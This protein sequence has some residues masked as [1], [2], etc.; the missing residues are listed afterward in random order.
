MRSKGEAMKKSSFKIFLL[1]FL[2]A[3]VFGFTIQANA[4]E[5]ADLKNAEI[6]L[7]SPQTVYT[8][9][10][11]EI[12]PSVAYV[13]CNGVTLSKSEYVISYQSN[14]NVGEAKVVVNASDSSANYYGSASKSFTITPK[15][16]E[17]ANVY[18]TYTKMTYWGTTC[19]P[20]VAGASVDGIS[21]IYGKD[22]LVEY[23]NN[24]NPGK[25]YV[26]LNGYG[27]FTGSVKK[28]F[29]INPATVS[30]VVQSESKT[31]SVT[32]NWY[33]Q[34]GISEYRIYEKTD[35]G[36]EYLTKSK[37][38]C[39]TIKKLNPSS[40][41]TYRIRA[42]KEIDSKN[43]AGDYSAEICAVTVPSRVNLI[44]V[45]K[46]KKDSKVNWK[47]VTCSKY[48]ILYCKNKNFSGDVKVKIVSSKDSSA[49]IKGIA[50]TK[51]Y[52]KI[53][54]IKTF[55]GVD[56]YGDFSSVQS[57]IFSHKYATYKTYYSAVP[58]RVNNLRLACKKID[59]TVLEPGETFSFD[60]VVGQRTKERGFKK[61]HVFS[62]PNSGA[63]GYGGGVCQVAST[64][65]NT[66]LLANMKIDLRYQ[67]VQRVGYVPLGRDAAISWGANNFKFTNNT[68]YPIKISAKLSN[69]SNKQAG[70]ITITFYTS[71]NVN[72]KKVSLKV[73]QK[74]KTFTLK[75]YVNGK[76]NYTT[77]STY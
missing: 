73:T 20:G 33:P 62:G 67:H 25:A 10:G 4:G 23:E 47:K 1:T 76:C 63:E 54:A 36:Y 42:V 35:N 48:E 74:N 34:P 72:P 28:S 30:S 75:R 71:E 64:I 31:D 65:F 55:N 7:Q 11:N 16:I 58:N 44:D 38:S 56:Y 66:A 12:R 40:V 22:Y 14:I 69:K 43:Y 61:A 3:L 39:I 19:T 60:A 15:S 24:I 13:I 51:Y 32:L 26:K 57:N 17:N 49:V 18:L 5:K 46:S 21:L 70:N 2:T 9:S 41:Y 6:I 77:K 53:R 59:G 50:K 52:F 37:E 8:Y 29:I 27:N 68:K 45:T